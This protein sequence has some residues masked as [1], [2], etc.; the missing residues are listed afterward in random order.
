MANVTYVKGTRFTSTPSMLAAMFYARVFARLERIVYVVVYD[1]TVKLYSV[2]H[3]SVYVIN[4][5]D[6]YDDIL[7]WVEVPDNVA[8]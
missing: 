6:E 4:N 5:G 1:V 8:P 7:I 2:Q 3:E